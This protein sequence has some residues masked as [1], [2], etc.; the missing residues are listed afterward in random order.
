MECQAVAKA[1]EHPDTLMEATIIQGEILGAVDT[2]T[3]YNKRSKATRDIDVINKHLA[4]AREATLSKA[5]E[6]IDTDNVKLG[7]DKET[8]NSQDAP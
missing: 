1:A 6:T 5:D 2:K 4:N 7:V 3:A 8:G